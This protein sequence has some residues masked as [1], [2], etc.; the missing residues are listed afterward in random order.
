M[1]PRFNP[2]HGTDA[3]RYRF[4]L[5]VCDRWIE[6]YLHGELRRWTSLSTIH[7]TLSLTFTMLCSVE[8]CSLCFGGIIF[9]FPKMYGRYMNDVL[10]K[11]HF[12]LTFI[13]FNC[14]FFPMHILGCRWTH[15]AHF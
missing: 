13:A 10:S 14:T 15:A 7:I 4:R 8:A 6:W 5:N 11:I 3:P 9:W 12:W 1:F 2:I